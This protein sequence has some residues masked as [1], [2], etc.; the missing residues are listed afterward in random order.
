[1][2]YWEVLN[3]VDGEHK[4]TPQYY[5]SIY[6][7]IV[8]AIRQVEPKMK[9]AGM[10]LASPI[11]HPEFFQYF[12]NPR[13]HKPGTPVDAISYHFYAVPTPDEDPQTMQHTF[14]AQADGFLNAVGYMETIRKHLSPSTQTIVDEIGVILPN[15]RQAELLKPI[16]NSY[17]N[18]SGALFAYVYARL[19]TMGIDMAH[20]SELIDYPGQC[21]G[22]N[23]IDWETGRPTA[24]YWVLKLLRDHL[25]PG[26][27]IV[28]TPVSIASHDLDPVAY[29]YAQGFVKKDGKRKILLINQRDRSFEVT[30]PGG[31]GANLEIVDQTTSFN[32]PARRQLKADKLTLPGFAVAVATLGN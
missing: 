28:D 20:E 7:A 1:M 21:A 3:E 31:A 30:I 25:G 5:T 26:D 4:M 9:F 32:P 2:V 17:W 6:D 16:P 15:A 27:K 14:F 10:A 19:A 29:V 11:T 18:L 12:L 8:A 23:V 24:R 22:T 13:N